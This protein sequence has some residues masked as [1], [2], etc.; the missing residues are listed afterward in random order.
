MVPSRA[1][2]IDHMGPDLGTA[3]EAAAGASGQLF[4]PRGRK[5]GHHGA[6]G[7]LRAA[8]SRLHNRRPLERDRQSGLAV[9]GC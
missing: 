1:G 9:A 7:R 8:W 3:R 5:P 6:V 4:C 2:V